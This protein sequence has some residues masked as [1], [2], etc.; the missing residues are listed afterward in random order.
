MDAG[1]GSGAIAGRMP[2]LVCGR[3]VWVTAP[4]S[5]VEGRTAG[6]GFRAP[7]T[8]DLR[9]GPCVDLEVPA[10][11]LGHMTLRW[12]LGPAR[13]SAAV[14][15][16]TKLL[17]LHSRYHPALQVGFAPLSAGPPSAARKLAFPS[18]VSDPARAWVQSCLQR[19]PEDRPTV[20]Q[21]LQHP[22]VTKSRVRARSWG[23]G[24]LGVCTE[25]RLPY[26]T[27]RRN[28]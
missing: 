3:G 28:A 23:W 25:V 4:V 20:Q 24:G 8:P 11:L 2:Q 12:R 27:E 9:R 26:G 14:R 6:G 18:S 15:R 22:W 7:G 17:D 10:L 21:L 16:H 5:T 1:T 13:C 19:A